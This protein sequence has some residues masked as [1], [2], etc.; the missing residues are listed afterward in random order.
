MI[1]DAFG[2]FLWCFT[3]KKGIKFFRDLIAFHF[4]YPEG[5]IVFTAQGFLPWVK[6]P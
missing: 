1:I 5:V 4:L 6:Y 3:V 2:E